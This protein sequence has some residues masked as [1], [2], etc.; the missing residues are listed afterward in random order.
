MT[1]VRITAGPYEF[2]A[3]WEREKSR[4]SCEA[5]EGLLPYRQRIIHVRWSGESIEAQ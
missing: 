3:R 2:Q 4:K 1:D 5:F